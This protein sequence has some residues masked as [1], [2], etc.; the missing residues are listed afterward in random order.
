MK[1]EKAI[2]FHYYSIFITVNSEP[3]PVKRTCL[4]NIDWG[5]LYQLLGLIAASRLVLKTTDHIK[6]QFCNG[7]PIIRLNR[8]LI[9]LVGPGIGPMKVHE[10]V[11]DIKIYIH[12]FVVPGY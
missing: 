3:D 4:A 8:H 1:F 7:L 12:F 10:T 9:E 11:V 5:K 2:K 6:S